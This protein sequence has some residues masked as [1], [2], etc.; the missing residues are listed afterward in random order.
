VSE[1]IVLQ[2]KVFDVVASFG[3]LIVSLIR[4]CVYVVV[5]AGAV[6]AAVFW[7]AE[8]VAGA[9]RAGLP[10]SI[11]QPLRD[12][13]DQGAPLVTAAISHLPFALPLP[14]PSSQPTQIPGK[15]VASSSSAKP[16]GPAA[17]PKSATPAVSVL[18]A[19]VETKSVPVVLDLIGSV[20]AVASIPVKVR[21]DS[22]IDTVTVKEGDRVTA[23]QTIFTLDSRA[24]SAQVAQAE[25]LVKR[26]MAVVDQTQAELNRVEPLVASK[27]LSPKD[28][29]TA[30]LNANSAKATLAADQA[31]L[32]NYKVQQSY[33][34]IKS[35]IDGRVGSLPYKPG[36]SIRAADALLLA[37]IN[38]VTPVYVAFS[39]PQ[40]NVPALHAAI[41]AGDVPVIVSIPGSRDKLTGKIAFTENAI[42]TATGTLLVKATVEN[43]AEKLLPGLSVNVRVVLRTDD[44]AV[45]VPEAAVL[46]G[47]DGAYA[48]VLKPD[49]TVVSRPLVVDRKVD[50]QVVIASG[51]EPGEQVITDGQARLV[52]NTRVEVRTTPVKSSALDIKA[53]KEMGS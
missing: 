29:D 45:T 30:K 31:S 8:I 39:A 11:V 21:I 3:K 52:P 50:G 47:Q 17:A 28:L 27:T 42:D 9:D 14:L 24:I 40:V 22:Q 34:E 35:P 7:R 33:Y 48:F 20:Q 25:A 43:S 6:Y 51:L 44:H 15:P 46:I 16:E 36:A 26:D 41:T 49:N 2:R 5:I 23:G 53:G 12:R 18:A 10:E 4:L 1:R 32:Q 19:K 13:L 37:T 38:Q